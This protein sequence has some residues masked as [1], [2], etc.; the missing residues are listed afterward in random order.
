MSDSLPVEA[1]RPSRPHK[2]LLWGVVLIAGAIIAMTVL[3]FATS[4]AP[5]AERTLYFKLPIEGAQ[6][7]WR[8]LD[9]EAFLSGELTLRIINDGHDQ[10]LVVFRDGVIQDGWEV[11]DEPQADGSIYFGF[12][13]N[14]RFRTKANDSLVIT[15]TAKEDL[16]GRGPYREGVLP[17]GTW[18]M[19]GTYSGLYGKRWNPIDYFVLQGDPPVAYLECWDD[20]WPITVT[21]REGW[22]GAKDSDKIGLYRKL[23]RPR[24]TNLHRCGSHY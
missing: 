16:R 19:H 12:A 14:E 1:S 4:L 10:T 15:L 2:L 24:G 20:V 22:R 11:I 3:P 17:A 18:Q 23:T 9:A 6:F 5:A 21:K 7:H 8:F 13:T